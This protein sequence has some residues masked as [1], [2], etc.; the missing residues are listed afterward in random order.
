MRLWQ[1]PILL[2][3]NLRLLLVKPILI[4]R[5]RRTA[6]GLKLKTTVGAGSRRWSSSTMAGDLTAIAGAGFTR[7]AGGTGCRIIRGAGPRFTTGVGSII[8]VGVGA[9]CP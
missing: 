7:I 5:F 2:L 1:P 3:Q 9:G 8:R 6:R 4:R